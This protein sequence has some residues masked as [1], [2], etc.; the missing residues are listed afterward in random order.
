MPSMDK[1]SKETIAVALKTATISTNTTTV[2]EIIDSA[3]YESIEFAVLSGT[4]TDGTYTPQIFGGDASNMSDEAQITGDEILGTC[5]AITASD[6]VSQ[7]GTC[8]KKRYFRIKIVS[9][10]VTT[11][12][13]VSA[14]CIKG[15]PLQQA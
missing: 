4:R 11:G 3:L 7:F 14:V 12:A 8:S 1:N 10:S 15:D 13:P 5:T 2:G 9:T 6:T